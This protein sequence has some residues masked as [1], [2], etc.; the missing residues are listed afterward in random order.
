MRRWLVVTV[1]C[2]VCLTAGS[3]RGELVRFE[4]ESRVPFANGSFSARPVPTKC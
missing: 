2:V 1:C 3:A 4:I